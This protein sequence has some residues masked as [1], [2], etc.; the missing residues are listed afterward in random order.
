LKEIILVIAALM[1]SLKNIYEISNFYKE[2]R[3]TSFIDR[4]L[5]TI[6]QKIKGKVSL[7]QCIKG[8][9]E[10]YEEFSNNQIQSAKTILIKFQ[11]V[12]NYSPVTHL[13]LLH[14]PIDA[15]THTVF[16][17]TSF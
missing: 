14:S 5:D 1:K 10:D 16:S 2:A 17:L 13:E 4:L 12:S 3:I 7:Y 9:M 11:E 15:V 6:V 8:G